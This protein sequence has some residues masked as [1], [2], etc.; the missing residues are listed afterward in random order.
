[1]LPPSAPPGAGVFLSLLSRVGPAALGLWLQA[2]QALQ[3]LL[4]LQAERALQGLGCGR[5]RA[6]S[7]SMALWSV[8]LL[9][10]FP[11]R[12]EEERRRREEEMRRQ[13]EEMMRRQQEGFKGNFPDAV[14]SWG[15][16]G[17]LR[18]CAAAGASAGSL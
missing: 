16:C 17:G 3:E 8:G 1:M 13:Q 11:C 15:V 18:V 2:E 6:G 10:S 9:G 12:Q 14:G 5:S 4:W 7:C